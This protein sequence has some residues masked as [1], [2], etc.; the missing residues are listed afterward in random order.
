MA[1]PFSSATVAHKTRPF[2]PS[3]TPGTRQ[4]YVVVRG[5]AHDALQHARQAAATAAAVLVVATAGPAAAR[6]EGVNKPELLPPG[7][8]TPVLDVADFLTEGEEARLRTRVEA[9]ER[10]TGVRLR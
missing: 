2:V 8:P 4:R 7:P 5:S 10:D 3:R 9:L 6:L 1:L